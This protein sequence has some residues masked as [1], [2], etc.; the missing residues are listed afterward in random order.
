[1]PTSIIE[2]FNHE[3]KVNQEEEFKE[4]F[5]SMF[6]VILYISYFLMFVWAVQCQIEKKKLSTGAFLNLFII[7]YACWASGGNNLCKI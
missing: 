4:G 5:K 6:F 7:Y 3:P 2:V 1:M